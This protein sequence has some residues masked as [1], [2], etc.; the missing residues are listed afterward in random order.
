MNM[1]RAEKVLKQV[2][3]EY[4]PDEKKLTYPTMRALLWNLF[5]GNKYHF[6]YDD[7]CE[8]LDKLLKELYD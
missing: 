7:Y 8:I 2:R 3:E 6:S 5:N 4:Y 1:T